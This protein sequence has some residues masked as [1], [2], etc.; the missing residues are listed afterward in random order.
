MDNP[1]TITD[2]FEWLWQ[3]LLAICAIIGIFVEITPIKF[4]PITSL[5][6][7]FYKPLKKDISDMK[8]ELN[9]KIENVRTDLKG[10]IDAI[11]VNQISIQAQINEMVKD[12]DIEEIRRIRWEIL[13]FSSSIDNNQLHTRDEYRHIKDDMKKY[14]ALIDKYGLTNGLIDEESEKIEKHYEENKNTTTFYF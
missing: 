11:K 10:E 2:V 13:E 1:L 5:L 8:V 4:N 3:N 12:I 14:H 7:L 6:N 9:D